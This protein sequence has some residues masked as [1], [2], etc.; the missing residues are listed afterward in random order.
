LSSALLNPV[1]IVKISSQ[2]QKSFC[3]EGKMIKQLVYKSQNKSNLRGGKK[4]TD[5]NKVLPKDKMLKIAF[6]MGFLWMV[7]QVSIS[8]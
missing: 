1:I 5:G 7:W 6:E 3:G 4:I 2:Y 8:D